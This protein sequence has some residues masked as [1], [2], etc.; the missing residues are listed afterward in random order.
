VI[1]IIR[2]AIERI[3]ATR[4]SDLTA[5]PFRHVAFGLRRAA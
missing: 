1:V 3:A 4:R 2:P 5:G